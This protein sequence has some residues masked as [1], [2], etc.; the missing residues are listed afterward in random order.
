MSVIICTHTAHIMCLCVFV[1]WMVAK[2]GWLESLLFINAYFHGDF[3]SQPAEIGGNPLKKTS[4]ICMLIIYASNWSSPF[5][6][7]INPQTIPN[8]QK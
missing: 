5:I 2:H 1:I 4:N 8:L 3:S 7:A 6:S